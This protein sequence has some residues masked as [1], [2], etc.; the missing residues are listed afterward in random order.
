VRSP[1]RESKGPDSGVKRVKIYGRNRA[2]SAPFPPSALGISFSQLPM[3]DIVDGNGNEIKQ[4]KPAEASLATL[5]ELEELELE[6]EIPGEA[7]SLLPAV[8]THM[9]LADS[10]RVFPRGG[11]SRGV[12]TSLGPTGTGHQILIRAGSSMHQFRAARTLAPVS[13]R[14]G[15]VPN[16]LLGDLIKPKVI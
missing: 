8:D 12:S 7:H 2:C 13:P 9:S 14:A 16:D 10:H 5:E 6:L 3:E 15:N 1:S 11:M 4:K